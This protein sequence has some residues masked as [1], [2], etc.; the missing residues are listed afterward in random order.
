MARNDFE[1]V[2]WISTGVHVVMMLAMFAIALTGWIRQR[3]IGYVVLATWA[4]VSGSWF[5]LAR[6]WYPLMQS[7]VGGGANMQKFF[8][9]TNLFSNVSMQ[10]LL[11]IGLALLVFSP[12]R[13]P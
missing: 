10:G 8:M 9:L 4:A 12:R 11:L 5:V 7:K 13:T 3:H 2:M 6:F 1:W